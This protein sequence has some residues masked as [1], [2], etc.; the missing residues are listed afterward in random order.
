MSAANVR[1][2]RPTL[3]KVIERRV[4]EA[5]QVIFQAQSIAAVLAAAAVSGIPANEERTAQTCDVVVEL[6]DKAASLLGRI[7]AREEEMD[8]GE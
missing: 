2:I 7:E 4:D 5:R 1:A 8:N 3:L 6:L